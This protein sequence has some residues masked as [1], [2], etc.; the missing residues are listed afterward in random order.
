MAENL[1]PM[2]STIGKADIG[3][4]G[5]A[6]LDGE[7]VIA[8]IL[9]DDGGVGP[10]LVYLTD[11]GSEWHFVNDAIKGEAWFPVSEPPYGPF[12]DPCTHALTMQ[13]GRALWT[14]SWRAAKEEG[15]TLS[16]NIFA[17]AQSLLKISKAPDV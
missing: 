10:Y 8:R 6:F 9:N 12:D 15:E 5:W 1:I 16:R 14:L 11:E 3:D 2:H 4:T 13:D 17:Y 7:W